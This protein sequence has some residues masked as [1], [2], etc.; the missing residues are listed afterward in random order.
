MGQVTVWRA[1]WLVLGDG[2]GRERGSGAHLRFTG[3]GRRTKIGRLMSP[4]R[5]RKRDFCR[6]SDLTPDEIRHVLDSA[7]RM[8]VALAQG[9]RPP[10][11]PGKTLAMIFEKPSLRT[12]CTFEIGMVQLGGHATYLAPHE[13]GLGKRESI[14]DIG[15]NLERW[16][17]IVMARTY[18]QATVDELAVHCR[19]PVINALSD[20]E[21]PCQAMADYLTL[22]ER[23]GDLK[24]FHLTYIGDGNNVCHSLMQIGAALGVHVTVSSPH[25]YEPTR[26]MA[27]AATDMGRIT[28]GSYT[29]EP[30]PRKAVARA[31]AVYTDVWA[32]MGQEAEA[33]ERAVIFHPYQVNGELMKCAP[34]GAFVMH[35]L[36]AHRGE[37]ITDEVMDGPTSV[38]FDQAE[39]RLHAQKAIMVFLD[40]Q[41]E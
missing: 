10:L 32:S 5:T 3:G 19:I 23:A 37:E 13:I 29:F 20:I 31:Q 12:R 39:N 17:D 15:R 21:H 25:R 38:V 18:A 35:D 4:I 36:P 2:C 40:A 34:A 30:D 41:S 33:E 8:K 26:E 11:L 28:G 14:H 9:A 24:G 22:L 6:S 16:F 1:T 7:Q 27:R